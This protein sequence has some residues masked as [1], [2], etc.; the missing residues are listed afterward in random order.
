LPRSFAAAAFALLFAAVPLAAFAMPQCQ[1]PPELAAMQLR[2]LQIELMVAA[3]NCHGDKL[4]YGGTYAIFVRNARS[5]LARNAQE[6]RAMFA[7]AGMGAG[8]I[9]QYQ[10]ELSNNAQVKSLSGRDYCGGV[11]LILADAARLPAA[12]LG[13]YAARTFPAPYGSKACAAPVREA[14]DEHNPS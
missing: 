11:A 1:T 10:T 7:R 13:A 4:D 2:Q 9:D 3:L 6:L 8:A 5:D 14:A 12:E